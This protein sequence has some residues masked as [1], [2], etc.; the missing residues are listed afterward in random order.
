MFRCVCNVCVCVCN[1]CVCVCVCVVCVCVCVCVCNRDQKMVQGH[2]VLLL[3]ELGGRGE[4][5][6]AGPC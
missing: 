6:G 3:E 4:G 5:G 1:V 2:H